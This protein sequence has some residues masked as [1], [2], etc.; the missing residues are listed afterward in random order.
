[1]AITNG[2]MRGLQIVVTGIVVIGAVW[3]AS[4]VLATKSEVEAVVDSV[5][6]KVSKETMEHTKDDYAQA[7]SESQRLNHLQYQA[8]K[9]DTW[10]YLEEHEHKSPVQRQEYREHRQQAE[11][12]YES[13][14]RELQQHRR[15]P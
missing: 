15:F 7:L 2:L 10:R 1:M 13:L 3:G 8:L 4:M 5:N 11:R 14:W 6:L 12:T 9:R